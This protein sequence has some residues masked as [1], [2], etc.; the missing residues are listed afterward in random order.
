VYATLLSQ[1]SVT[2][3]FIA[4]FCFTPAIKNFYC[5]DT[6]I[7]ENG[8]IHCMRASQNGFI[9]YIVSYVIFFITYFA[10]ACCESVRRKSPGNII[11]MGIFTL[12]CSMWVASITIYHDVT[13]VLMAVGITA[14][15]CLGLTLFSF[16]TRFD[17][18]GWGIYLF[19]ASWIL[20]LFG[21]MAIIFFARDYPMIHTGNLKKLIL[22]NHFKKKK[23]GTFFVKSHSFYATF[24]ANTLL[25]GLG[26][27]CAQSRNHLRKYNFFW[28]GWGKS[29]NS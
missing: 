9:I 2:I 10:I 6:R 20:F 21:I 1:L 5:T 17:F 23:N 29:R 8:L 15:L 14:A 19:A 22:R 24:F 27:S 4:V 11:A 18:T 26:Q 13:W 3:G 12:A 16:Q 7:D 28:R 25:Y